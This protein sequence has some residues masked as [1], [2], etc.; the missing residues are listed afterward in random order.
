MVERRRDW[1]N[2]ILLEDPS[3][4]IVEARSAIYHPGGHNEG[5]PDALKNMMHVIYGFLRS[6]IHIE[7]CPSIRLVRFQAPAITDK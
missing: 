2:E 5:W 4:F 3:L 7:M 1:A 6:L